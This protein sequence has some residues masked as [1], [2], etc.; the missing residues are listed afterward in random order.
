[1]LLFHEQNHHEQISCLGAR[2]MFRH[3]AFIGVLFACI[4]SSAI[5]QSANP[6]K[7]TVRGEAVTKAIAASREPDLSV[8]KLRTFSSDQASR[9]LSKFY[10]QYTHALTEAKIASARTEQGDNT[11]PPQDVAEME[12]V[13]IRGFELFPSLQDDVLFP[14]T[15]EVITYAPESTF[16]GVTAFTQKG[17]PVGRIVDKS[18]TWHA[19][20]HRPSFYVTNLLAEDGKVI[21]DGSTILYVRWQDIKSKILFDA[22]EKKLEQDHAM[23]VAALAQAR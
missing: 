18:K 11:Q 8:G 12:R 15:V 9:I 17:K 16:L 14:L 2:R 13:Q 6:S 19:G 5:G 20:L 23:E 22:S 7:P 10:E 3:K 21:A 4:G 1:M